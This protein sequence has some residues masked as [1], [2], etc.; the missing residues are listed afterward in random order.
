MN[1]N[2]HE[3]KVYSQNGEDGLIE[4][5][6]DKIGIKYYYC[7]EFGVESGAECN[8]RYFIEKY[9]SDFLHMDS[10][11]ESDII[12]KELITSENIESLFAKY[13][14]PKYFDLL[15]ID[16]DFNDYYVWKAIENYYPTVV[17]I[18]Y[19]AH[20]PPDE[21][22]VVKYGPYRTWDGTDYFGASL[23]ALKNLGDKKGYRLIACDNNGVN[24]FFVCRDYY[25]FFE[26]KG[27][28][29]IYKS[30]GYEKYRIS[31]ESM[32]ILE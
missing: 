9:K 27:I 23:L 11:F 25:Y 5:I 22:K 16:I 21:S 7:V 6:F 1:L 30:A 3:K 15:S 20:I 10:S 29:D 12:K 13:N 26:E 32:I 18:E 14:V 31:N 28:T 4:Y 2:L 8:T 24:A 17:I 19:N